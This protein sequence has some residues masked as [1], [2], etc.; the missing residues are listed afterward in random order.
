MPRSIFSRSWEP[1]VALLWGL[2]LVWTVWLAI[3]WI[4]PV[5]ATALGLAGDAP[6]PPNP[7]LRRAALLLAQNADIIWLALATMNLHL[8]LTKAH[9]LGSARA[10]LA[11][12]A[13]GA[14]LLG[15]LN[16]KTG[17][18]FG[19]LHFGSALG[20]QVFG[21]AAGWVLLWA[22]LVMAAREAVLWMFP[23]ASHRLVSLLAAITVLATVANLHWPARF[24]RGWWVLASEG[25]WLNGWQYWASWL[26]WPGL[27]AFAMRE[28][29]VAAAVGRRSA[30]PLIILALL[31][32]IALA[33]RW[34]L[35]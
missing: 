16:A 31:N 13:G 20:A 2:F 14:L 26:I 8:A 6:T 34:R 27:M 15:L 18:L 7:D 11:F 25:G 35:N 23:R 5:G 1:L 21:I 32:A 30:R 10:W 29:D 9:G 12:S 28:R 3:V 33:S 17:L 24:I 19:M 4:T 22:V